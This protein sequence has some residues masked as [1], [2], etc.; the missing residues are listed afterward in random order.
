MSKPPY[1]VP[2]MS[3]IAALPCHGLKVVS[4]FSGCGGTCLGFRM[5]GFETLW[6][7]E[8]IPAAK[9]VYEL[10]HPGVPVDD[11]DIRDVTPEEI[12]ERIGLAKG[13]VDV[14]E[15]SPPCASFSTAGRREET[16]GQVKKYSEIRQRVD[17][18][19]WEFARIVEGLQPRAF[20]AENVSGLV[21]GKAKGYFKMIGKRA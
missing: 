18:L 1:R 17:D 12:L 13:E 6:A 20:C 19:F 15:G 10:N 5:A 11:R 8:F 3:E 16:W 2:S 9:E 21:K 14:V 4:T 7:S